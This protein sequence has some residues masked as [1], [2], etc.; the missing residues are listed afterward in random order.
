VLVALAGA[1]A[2]ERVAARSGW[3]AD[4][5]ADARYTISPATEQALAALSGPLTATLYVEAGDNRAR[6][7][8]LLLETLAAHADVTVRERDLEQSADDVERYDLASSNT[9]VLSIGER[10]TTVTRPTEG[11]LYEGLRRLVGEQ[12]HVA[13]LARGEGEGDAQRPDEAGFSGLAE[14]LA[15]EGFVVRDLVLSAVTE[16]PDDASLLVV[17]GP[18][19]PLRAESVAA[20]ERWL[21]RGGRLVAMLDPGFETGLEPLLE[22]FGFGLPDAVIVDPAAG[23]VEGDPPGVNPIA[24]QFSQHPVTQGLSGTRMVFFRKARPVLAERK[25]TPEDQIQPVVFASRRSWLA[26]NASAVQR[27]APP[28][29]PETVEEEYWPLVAVGRYPRKTDGAASEA[30][31]TVFGDSDFA[32]NRSL[33]ALYNLDLLMNAIQWTAHREE[34]ITLRPKSLTPDQAPLTPQQ[35]L[36]MLYGVGLL[37]PQLCLAA[38]A[39]TWSRRRSA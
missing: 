17:I 34:A 29:R 6:S 14:A 19:R 30:R 20:I 9:V 23:P 8:R 31:I 5:T 7:T 24:F 32:S 21:A 4:L 18:Q 36:D 35:S 12:G 1:I 39:W 13:Y 33:R 25:P 11:S 28:A 27:G 3:E 15:T 38:A 2:A 22:R 37:V 10:H 16:M 26:P